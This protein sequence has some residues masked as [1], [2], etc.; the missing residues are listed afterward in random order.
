MEGKTMMEGNMVKGWKMAK[1]ARVLFGVAAAAVWIFFGKTAA[2]AATPENP[3]HHCTQKDDGSDYTDWSY[4]YFGSYPQS[5][6][7]G[8]ALTSAIT[9]ANYDANGDAWVNGTK[10]RRISKSDTDRTEYFG[11]A[12]Y[13]YFKWE[14]IR[15]R[16]LQNDGKTLFV[17]ADKG[18][19]CK[20]YNE[21]YVS[22][23]TWETCTLRNWLNNEFYG[24]AFNSGEQ[25]AVV[26]Q[27]VVNE[28]NPE[29]GTAGENNTADKVFLLSISE[30]TKQSCGFCKSI[31]TSSVSRRVKPS[32]YAHIRGVAKGTVF[33][34]SYKEN[35]R[36]LLRS[37]GGSTADVNGAGRVDCGTDAY[38]LIGAACM[39]ALHINLSSDL[40]SVTDDGTSGSGGGEYYTAPTVSNP[41]NQSV[42]SGTGAMFTVS[43]GGGYPNVYTY[44]WYYASSRNG[45]GT[46]ISGATA[47]SYTITSSNMTPSLNGRYY[48]CV[49]SNGQYEVESGRAKLT[50]YSAPR[51]TSS[52][53]R[54]VKPGNSATFSVTASGGNPS[55]YTYQWYYASSQSGIGTQI[56]GA[57]ASSYTI[58]ANNVTISLNGRY[59]YCIVSN[60][61][62]DVISSRA[63]LTVQSDSGQNPSSQPVISGLEEWYSVAAGTSLS[64]AVS[65]SGGNPNSYTYQWYY[66]SSETGIGTRINGATSSGYTI[67]SSEMTETIHGR[68]YY[69]IVSNGVYSV[70]SRRTRVLVHRGTP[71][72]DNQTGGNQNTGG[73][74]PTSSGLKAQTINAVSRT[75]S[76]QKKEIFL[77]ASTNGD[78]RLTYQS[79]NPKVVAVLS[80]GRIKIKNFGTA[81]ITITASQT[82]SYAAASKQI[83]I[84]VVPKKGGLKKALSPYSR[85]L[86]LAWKKDKKAVGYEVQISMSKSF[87][88]KTIKRLYKKGKTDVTLIGLQSKKKYYVRIRSYAQAGKKKVYGDW[89]KAKTVKIR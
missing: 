52:S 39:P 43:A 75:V 7:T 44:Q 88:S 27:N 82:A 12:T 19:D 79:S 25:N 6:V 85:C 56:S 86:K 29:H 31:D 57:T 58:S 70:E 83:T 10:Y 8:S 4:V 78:G 23:I 68:Y 77:G 55:S 80:D 11:D 51:V 42:K 40:W 74:S 76:Y 47:S 14:R 48:Y 50:V 37:P 18:L 17:M 54:I 46:A 53:D 73:G 84:K 30:A 41:S 66:A 45:S 22:T 59:Y 38:I 36:W 24:T 26:Q 2:Y 69:C 87:Q 13:R 67:P 64:L 9:S 49:V 35:C 62:Y 34:D 21:I 61:Q 60:G 81:V 63:K 5:E 15:W 28:N 32:D 89:S 3:V 33:G 16:V 71:P 20:R 72:G 1:A 65:A